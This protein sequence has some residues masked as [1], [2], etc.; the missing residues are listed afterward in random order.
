MTSTSSNG[1]VRKGDDLVERWDAIEER[2]RKIGSMQGARRKGRLPTVRPQAPTLI[3]DLQAEHFVTSAELRELA[4]RTYRQPVISV[5]LNL[6]PDR[7]GRG[8]G[9]Y[10]TM[11]ESESLDAF[12]PTD[13]VDAGR[14][15]KV[16]RHRL[17]PLRWH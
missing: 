15:G 12:V 7:A 3:K 14:P 6:T 1:S 17:T 10:L 2:E 8:P 4:T 9:A 13:T 5:Y 16:Q 11:E